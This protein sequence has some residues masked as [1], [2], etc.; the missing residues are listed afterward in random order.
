MREPLPGEPTEFQDLEERVAEIFELPDEEQAAAFAKLRRL[1]PDQATLLLQWEREALAFDAAERSVPSVASAVAARD[2]T[3]LPEQLGSYKILDL[4]GEG[5]MGTVFLAEQQEPVRRRVALKVVRAGMAARDVLAR[6]EAERQALAMMTHANIARVLDAGTTPDGRPYFALE[7]VPGLA[8]T[9]YCDRQRLGLRERIELFQKVC[10]GVQHAHQKGILHRDLKPSNILV[11]MRDGFA[12]PKIIDFGLA[13]ALQQKLTE[14]TLFTE[15]GR[16]LGTPEYMSPEQ[17]EMSGLDIDTRSDLYSLGVLLYELLVGGLPFESQKLRL[18]GYLE[19]QRQIREEE[20]ERPSTRCSTVGDDIVRIARHRRT[21]PRALVQALHGDLDWI[22]MR[23]LEKDPAR[24]YAAASELATDLQRHLDDEPVEARPPSAW[25]RC[26][27]FLRKRRGAVAALAAVFVA[28]TTGLSVALWKTAEATE[29]ARVAQDNLAE[30]QKNER[31]A[32]DA[33]AATARE[34]QRSHALNLAAKSAQALERDPVAALLLSLEAVDTDETPETLGRVQTALAEQYLVREFGQSDAEFTVASM[35]AFSDLAPVSGRV[36]GASRDGAVKIWSLDGQELYTLPSRG[37]LLSARFSDD[38]QRVLVVAAVEPGRVEARAFDQHGE[39][40]A[41]L[42]DSERWSCADWSADGERLIVRD[43]RTQR[44]SILDATGALIREL[45]P[46]AGNVA[47]VSFLESGE[48]VLVLSTNLWIWP[49]DDKQPVRLVERSR[50]WV[51]REVE[52]GRPTIH[53]GG[54]YTYFVDHTAVAVDPRGEL[55]ATRHR[56]S[57]VARLWSRSGEL[58]REL[59]GHTHRVAVVAFSPS[60]ASILTASGDG[61]ARLWSRS[62]EPGPVLHH[63]RSLQGALFMDSDRRILTKSGSSV[64]LWN[65]TGRRLTEIRGARFSGVTAAVHDGLLLTH[66]PS[67]ELALWRLRGVDKRHLRSEFDQPHHMKT[68]KSGHT[69]V[70]T[71][72]GWVVA[73]GADGEVERHFESE[74]RV[75]IRGLDVS[76]DGSKVVG[77]GLDRT[78]FGWDWESRALEWTYRIGE[79]GQKA[80]TDVYFVGTGQRLVVCVNEE[81]SA[82]LVDPHARSHEVLVDDEVTIEG[83]AAPGC[84]RAYV[85]PDRQWIVLH[86]WAGGIRLCNAEGELVTDFQ[87]PGGAVPRAA[88]DRHSRWIAFGTLGGVVSVWDLRAVLAKEPGLVPKW[89]R[90]HNV[91]INQVDFSPDGRNLLVVLDGSAYVTDL[92][93]NEEFRVWPRETD[94]GGF[95]EPVHGYSHD[96]SWLIGAGYDGITRWPATKKSLLRAARDFAAL[97]RDGVDLDLYRT[98]AP[99]RREER[100]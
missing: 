74:N 43:A 58:V 44:A 22:V 3:D 70:S 7:H 60:G 85:S 33:E 50:P 32:L 97:H 10:L 16:V 77:G 14:R 2:R 95:L 91:A 25:Y 80:A 41:E 73:W 8:I 49:L 42:G 90:K 92:D 72:D 53:R 67:R 45:R 31:R 59:R 12:E 5:G 99:D 93:G 19:M 1:E 62:G 48:A 83:S 96:G 87:P 28:M 27:K 21:E 37:P 56:N 100:D 39:I 98:T 38:E 52:G 78:L 23:C 15:Q 71:R 18:A 81:R 57:P 66:G 64:V 55:I 35:I 17:A 89:Q 11:Q 84:F 88:I 47:V 68:L 46:R 86:A 54:P 4:L 75:P 76:P 94:I 26:S 20:P 63:G 9:S 36:L 24:R 65:S 13:K 79:N 40:V 69:L 30:S 6:F 82:Y 34:L 51:R 61:T 29:N